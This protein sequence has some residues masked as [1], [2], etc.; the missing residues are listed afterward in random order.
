MT[1]LGSKDAGV[2][3]RPLSPRQARIARR[4]S[5]QVGPGPATFFGDAC[6]L[7]NEE[8]SHLT[9][10]HLVA[11]LLRDVESAV[12]SVL[13]PRDDP[14]AKVEHSHREQILAVLADVGLGH[15]DIVAELW[16]GMAGKGRLAGLAARAHRSALDPPRMVDQDFRDFVDTMEQVLDAVLEGFEA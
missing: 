5:L 12:R 3:A 4:L 13:K 6:A 7:L 15:D 16:L 14:A 9:V 10:T 8:P 1:Q 11:H 2:R